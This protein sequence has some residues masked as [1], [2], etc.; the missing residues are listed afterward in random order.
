MTL[1]IETDDDD[2]L[3]VALGQARM[4]TTGSERVSLDEV[5]DH[6]GYTREE[7]RA[8]PSYCG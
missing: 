8:H 5:L 3:D 4:L 7:L 2:A 6:F 1:T